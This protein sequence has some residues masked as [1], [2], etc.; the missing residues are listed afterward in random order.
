MTLQEGQN[1]KAAPA[2]AETPG[3]S[4]FTVTAEEAK[5]TTF[6]DRLY[7]N[8]NE[9]ILVHVFCSFFAFV[10]MKE[11]QSWAER[12][13]YAL[14]WADVIRNLDRLQETEL[15]QDAKRFL[16]R[17]EA[18]GTCGKVFQAAQVALPPTVRR[19]A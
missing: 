13:G 1:D 14:V 4:P 12:F 2:I 11:L 3:A 8:R 7:P 5:I 18:S 19:V 15:E 6:W 10:L 16:L 9:T 17:T